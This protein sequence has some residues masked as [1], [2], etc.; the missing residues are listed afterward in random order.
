MTQRMIE[1]LETIGELARCSEVYERA[2][3]TNA[4]AGPSFYDIVMDAPLGSMTD[5]CW[6]PWSQCRT[7]SRSIFHVFG[8][9]GYHTRLFGAFGLDRRLDPHLHMHT[10]CERLDESLRMYGIDEYELQDPSFTCQLALAH[11]RDVLE[12]AAATLRDPNRG[13]NAL[14]VI[15]L[16]GCQDAHKCTFHDMDPHKVNIPSMNFERGKYDERIFSE[17]VIHDDPRC[18]ES[19]SHGREALRRAARLHDWIR[20]VDSVTLTKEE[21]VRTITGMHRFSWKCLEQLDFGLSQIIQ[22]LRETNRY[23]DAIIYLFSDHAFSLYEHGEHCETPW[24]SCLRTFAI[25]K[26]PHASPTRVHEPLSL[27]DLPHMLFDDCRFFCDWH[28][29]RTLKGTCITLGL[30]VSWLARANVHPRC[31]PIGLR[32]FFVRAVTR[33]NDR[34]YA[35]A[36][37]FSLLDLARASGINTERDPSVLSRVFETRT[38]WNNPVLSR[39]FS[40]FGEDD[41]FQVYDLTSDR[42]ELHDLSKLPEWCRTDTALAVKQAVD[43]ALRHHKLE[44]LSLIVPT[45]VHA[46]SANR[47]SVC[48]V[49]LHNR[50]RDLIHP[51]E[52]APSPTTTMTPRPALRGAATQTE[53]ISMI[54]ALNDAFGTDISTAIASRLTVRSGPLT[55]FAPDGLSPDAQLPNWVPPPLRGAH[56]QQAML[57]AADRGLLLTDAV[58]GDTHRLTRT[59]SDTNVLMRSCRILLQSA[60]SL[61]Y[62]GGFIIG[63]RVHE[64]PSISEAL[65]G[66]SAEETSA[67]MIELT[68]NEGD[69]E[70]TDDTMSVI[71]AAS[72][73]DETKRKNKTSRQHLGNSMSHRRPLSSTT[74]VEPI[75][76]STNTRGSVKAKE[77]G[78]NARKR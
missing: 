68:P 37:W 62:S 78:Q 4:C 13:E 57:D 5:N 77:Q 23:D 27:G 38:T 1:E 25:R 24:D 65:L 67:D 40:E 51:L 21:L 59:A 46:L 55:V 42:N 47:V 72:G 74:R 70:T 6:H 19:A 7:T 53:D 41:A 43:D 66:G 17:S 73:T 50:V 28:V 32:T 3:P 29:A 2:Y 64:E 35:V 31:D 71:S 75:G 44:M 10:P 9:N 26:A 16:L 30:A 12:R 56:E 20:G 15:N 54:K 58:N 69:N 63:Y 39:S 76:L 34:L 22:A 18:A 14:T 11:D 48:S 61:I 45:N 8:Q 49:M 60:T 33:H 36:F 52:R